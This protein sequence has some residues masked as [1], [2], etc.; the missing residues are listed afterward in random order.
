LSEAD[1]GSRDAGTTQ[2]TIKRSTPLA[3]KHARG[4]TTHENA[5]ADRALLKN[6]TAMLSRARALG[7]RNRKQNPV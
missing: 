7:I 5:F 1:T 4:S 3:A 6:K 2:R